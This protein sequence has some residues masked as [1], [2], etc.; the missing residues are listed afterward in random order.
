MMF[1]DIIFYSSFLHK[2]WSKLVEIILTQKVGIYNMTLFGWFFAFTL[3]LSEIQ[4]AWVLQSEQTGTGLVFLI[5]TMLHVRVCKKRS[6]KSNVKDE[7]KSQATCKPGEQISI[8]KCK[9]VT[10]QTYAAHD[11][12][13]CSIYTWAFV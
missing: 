4:A 9:A 11:R 3:F 5:Q 7:K 6:W 12:Y 1:Y 8:N 2:F 13:K 10:L